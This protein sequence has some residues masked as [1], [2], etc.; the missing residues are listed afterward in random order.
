ML[1]R[2]Y[3]DL[4]SR[5]RVIPDRTGIEAAD[6]EEALEEAEA[7]LQE[8]R[9]SGEAAEFDEGWSLLIRD[10][11]GASLRKLP[12]LVYLALTQM[13]MDAGELLMFITE[14]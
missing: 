1:K 11:A 12:I 9:E 5:E 2:F 14:A 8:M 7:A 3:F 4:V 10:E 6:L 13:M